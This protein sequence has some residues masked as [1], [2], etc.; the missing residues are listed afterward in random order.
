M[1]SENDHRAG[2]DDGELRVGVRRVKGGVFSN[3]AA[4]QLKAGDTLRVK[5]PGAP[6]NGR[7]ITRPTLSSPSRIFRAIS[8]IS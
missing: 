6:V 5:A 3:W 1:A 7:A 4:T 8:Q 2:V